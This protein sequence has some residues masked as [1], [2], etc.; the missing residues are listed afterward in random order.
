MIALRIAMQ[1]MGEHQVLSEQVRSLG[2]MTYLLN[3]IALGPST[4]QETSAA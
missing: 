2:L 4:Q 1:R 3:I